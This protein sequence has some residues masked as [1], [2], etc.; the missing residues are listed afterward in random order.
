[1]TIRDC[2]KKGKVELVVSDYG[3]K[4]ECEYEGDLLGRGIMF[5]AF[6]KAMKMYNP[7][8]SMQMIAIITAGGIEKLLGDKCDVTMV[9][10]STLKKMME[11]SCDDETEF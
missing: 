6:C 7:L 4:G 2:I 9:D 1:M 11:E 3:I 8:D 10:M 5:D